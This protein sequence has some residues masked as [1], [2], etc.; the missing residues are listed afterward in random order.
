EV[1][2]LAGIMAAKKTAELIPLC[3]PLALDG[4]TVG[5]TFPDERTVAIEAEVK[6]TART[7]VE[8]EALTA[9]SVAALTVYDMCKAIDRGMV[10]ADIRL[11]EK[12]GGRSGHFRRDGRP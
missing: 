2:R 6:I 3:H 5:F 8:M 10:I 11:E 9:V 4:V 1:A 7:G 12:S